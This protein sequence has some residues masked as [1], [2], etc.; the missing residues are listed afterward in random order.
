MQGEFGHKRLVMDNLIKE[1]LQKSEYYYHRYDAL[2]ELIASPE[3]IAHNSYLR[4]LIKEQKSLE[5]IYSNRKLLL[6]AIGE[7]NECISSLSKTA[8]SA[9]EALLQKEVAM[10]DANINALSKQI[11]T[12]IVPMNNGAF[13][14]AILTIK[15]K[16]TAYNFCSL[17]LNMYKNYCNA[18]GL[19]FEEKTTTYLGGVKESILNIASKDAYYIFSN[20]S[21]AHKATGVDAGNKKSY[22]INV[23]VLPLVEKE[24]L[25]ISESDIRIDL[26]HSGGA[27]GQN[28]NKVETAVRIKHIPT[29]VIVNC[30]DERSQLK[31]KERAL[32]I[33]LTRLEEN[34]EK[35][36]DKAR[37]VA[38]KEVEDNVKNGNI[39]R[40]YDF[41][42]NTVQDSR[43]VY[44]KNLQEA[45]SGDLDDIMSAIKVTTN[46]PI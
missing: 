20:E 30:Q 38:K 7:R 23:T 46:K 24:D 33:L 41:L 26:F 32:K 21:G 2:E 34:R 15:A 36:E 8:D 43:V 35:A 4:M 40:V 11:L 6:K 5:D 22:T 17:I 18:K 13:D 42:Y 14:G 12:S 29:G 16:G 10:L 19:S 3:I 44:V 1:I 39:T 25:Q 9:Y 28:V 37:T 45:L 27:G 31:N